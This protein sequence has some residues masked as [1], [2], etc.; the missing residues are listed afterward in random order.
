MNL[1]VL[2]SYDAFIDN[3]FP[4]IRKL[5]KINHSSDPGLQ[6]INEALRSMFKHDYEMGK[7]DLNER[8]RLIEYGWDLIFRKG[9]GLFIMIVD[10]D[11]VNMNQFKRNIRID[12]IIS[13][14]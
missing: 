2:H 6:E 8:R 13:L 4:K 5:V 9:N 10:L 3:K 12:S 14:P 7:K 1:H 11:H